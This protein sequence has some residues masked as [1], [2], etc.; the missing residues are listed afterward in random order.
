L[1]V[2]VA[3]YAYERLI[4]AFR[5]SIR[6][7]KVLKMAAYPGKVLT[8]QMSKPTNFKYMSGQYM[9]VNCPAVSPFEWYA[10]NNLKISNNS[11]PI[12]I[13]IYVTIYISLQ[14]SIFNNFYTTRRLSERSYKSIGRLDRGYPRS[15]L[16][17]L[18]LLI[19]FAKLYIL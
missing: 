1:A 7:V 9:F 19:N 5:S 13:S 11:K 2:P 17:G 16:R 4:R 6:T 3:L 12:S 14:A 10:K 15:F 8:L 18:F